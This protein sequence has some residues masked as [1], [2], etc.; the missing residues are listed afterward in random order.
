M[1]CSYNIV[2]S[3]PIARER[4]DKHVSMDTSDQQTFPWIRIHYIRREQNLV[5]ISRRQA[6]REVSRSSDE[7]RERS[8]QIRSELS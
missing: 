1:T 8:D 2:T 6:R 7:N 5:Q 4:D 3:R